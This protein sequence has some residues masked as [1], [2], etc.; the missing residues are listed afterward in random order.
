MKLFEV[1]FWNSHSE[2]PNKDTI[3]LVR[4]PD[5]MRAVEEVAINS[6]PSN[7]GGDKIR[8]AHVVFEIG[9]DLSPGAVQD[10]PR[11][12]RGP[13]FASAYNHGWRA[14]HRQIEGAEYT[15]EWKEE[16]HDA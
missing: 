7:H 2:R 10:H 6:S 9:E 11:I 8:L 4:A 5:F 1:I 14:W 15:R 16:T 12:L 3:Y 13:Y